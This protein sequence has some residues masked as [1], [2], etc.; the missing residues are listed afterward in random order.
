[1][2]ARSPQARGTGRLASIAAPARGWNTR[3]PLAGME[4]GF[5]PIFDNFVV[6]G[7]QPI[8]RR[9]Y[10][11][12]ATGLPGR[13][14]G[15]LNYAGAGSAQA[16]FA[17]S[18][19]GIYNVTAG[20]AVGAAVVSGLTSARWDALNFAASGGNFML[21]WNATDTERTYNGASWANWAPTGITGRVAWA[22]SFKGR[23]FV[24]V[25]GQLGFYYGGAGA[26]A[27]AFTDFPLQGIARR[28]GS[29]VAMATLTQDGA[30]GPDD[31][32]VFLTSEGEAIVYAGTDPSS[33][34]TWGLIGRWLLPRPVGAPHRCLVSYG[35]DALLMTDLGVVPMT[36]FNNTADAATIFDR[37]ATTRYIE[38]AWRNLAQERRTQSGWIIAPLTRFGLVVMNAP[39]GATNAQQIVL[40]DNGAISRWAGIPAAVWAEGLGGRVFAGDATATGR[41]FLYGEDTADAGNGLQ[42]E[43]VTAFS[44]LRSPGRT[45]RATQLQAVIRDAAGA[46]LDVRLLPD[47][48]V[49]LSRVDAGGASAPASA[50]PSL[51]GGA[52]G[53]WDTSLWDSGALWGG[54]A[55]Q[56]SSPWRSAAVIGQAMAARLAGTSG[57][58]RPAWLATNIVAEAG[59]PTA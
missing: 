37:V 57:N 24:G 51:G 46:D 12:W 50:L 31:I 4:A 16:L 54:D 40:S 47:W 15:L 45:K 23:L 34:Q 5:A 38:D 32:A 29:V 1:M 19:A 7:G 8:V 44:A 17:A 39:W 41:V 6:E 59:G 58:G 52:L 21:A 27:G 20:G 9:G 22:A 53:I 26:I 18:G 13:V 36:A 11:V 30:E 42:F 28:G 49:P 43:A 33:A 14:D 10:R 2:L 3:D 55:G 56:V 48:Q 35:G 25:P